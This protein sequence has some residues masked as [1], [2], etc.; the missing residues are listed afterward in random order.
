MNLG[1][2]EARIDLI[3]QA[4]DQRDWEVAHIEED[5]LYLSIIQ[6]IADDDATEPQEMAETALEARNIVE[7]RWYA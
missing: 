3:R 5:Q 7:V 2:V 1:D 6:A 4:A